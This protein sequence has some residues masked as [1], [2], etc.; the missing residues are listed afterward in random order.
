M[1]VQ[2]RPTLVLTCLFV[3]GGGLAAGSVAGS[4]AH[5]QQPLEEFVRAARK[6]S[7][8]VREARALLEQADW[9]TAEARGRLLPMASATAIYTRNESEIAVNIPRDGMIVKALITPQDQRDARVALVVPLLDLGAWATLAQVGAM[10]DVAEARLA[11]TNQ[12]VEVAVV[13]LW[14][15][16]VAT[17]AMVE[18]AQANLDAARTALVNAEARQAAGSGTA[19]QTARAQAEQAR[20]VQGLEDARLQER[21]TGQSLENLTGLRPSGDRV[22]LSAELAEEK[23]LAHFTARAGQQPTVALAR[24]GESAAAAGRTAAWLALLPTLSATAAERITNAAGFGP[25]DFW[26]IMV[27]ATWNLDFIKPATIGARSN[28]LEVAEVQEERARQSAEYAVFDA[29]HRVETARAKLVAAQTAAAASARVS[30]DMKASYEVGAS[31]QLDAI[32]ADRDRFAAEVGRIQAEAELAAARRILRIRSG[33]ASQGTV[34]DAEATNAEAT[35][36]EATED[37]GR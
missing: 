8:D 7:F 10:E 22:T 11:V 15:Q 4:V 12:T 18:A 14:H 26:S 1:S 29:W 31:T 9:Q 2:L 37:T 34:P 28:G 6:H 25:E 35:N 5:A 27:S 13:Q 36:A 16:L 17:R 30:E 21:L 32:Q 33:V 3:L 24:A 19:S 23:P 20:A